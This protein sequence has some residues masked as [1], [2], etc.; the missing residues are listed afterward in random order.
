[1]QRSFA[2]MGS[3]AVI[4][5][6][7]LAAP[8]MGALADRLGPRLL[9]SGGALL[10]VPAGDVTLIGVPLQQCRPLGGVLIALVLAYLGACAFY[11]RPFHILG[12]AFTRKDGTP[13]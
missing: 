9:I 7:G 8:F 2:Q 3:I 11:R 12:W 5:L 1:M 6:A 13:Y 4:T 10:T